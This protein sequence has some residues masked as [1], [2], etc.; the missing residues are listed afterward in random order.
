M[1]T[2]KMNGY[3]GIPDLVVKF[4]GLNNSKPRLVN[5]WLLSPPVAIMAQ[6]D[7][8]GFSP[9]TWNS[10]FVPSL[11]FGIAVPVVTL[12]GIGSFDE[13]PLM[14]PSLFRAQVELEIHEINESFG[15]TE[16]P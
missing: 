8:A 13:F 15:C 10:C 3:R 1:Q 7:V 6:Y 12:A 4:T 2:E 9:V 14:W 16:T 5:R 11:K